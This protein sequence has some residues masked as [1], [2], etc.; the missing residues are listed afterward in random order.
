MIEEKIEMSTG[1]KLQNIQI[2]LEAKDWKEA[3]RIASVPLVKCGSIEE[4]YVENMI[5]SVETLG[6]YIV[7]MPQFAL[8]HAAPCEYVKN[9][10]F[11][12]QRLKMILNFIVITIP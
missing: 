1:I 10:I 2:G 4:P 7:I 8:A 6:P 12:S 5:S 11:Q 9:R 3:I